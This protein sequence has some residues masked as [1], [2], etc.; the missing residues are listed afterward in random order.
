MEVDRIVESHWD[1]VWEEM[2]EEDAWD[3]DDPDWADVADLVEGHYT[4]H[5]IADLIREYVD[6]DADECIRLYR[7]GYISEYIT[8]GLNLKDPDDEWAEVDRVFTEM[9]DDDEFFLSMWGD[10]DLTE[11]ICEGLISRA[12]DNGIRELWDDDAKGW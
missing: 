1:R 8:P 10:S 11:G 9:W 6:G 12:D 5:E 4:D 7:A 2:N 3:R